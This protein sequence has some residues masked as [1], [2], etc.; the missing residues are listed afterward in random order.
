MTRASSF[1]DE[2]NRA[3]TIKDE[4][5]PQQH[6]RSVLTCKV[7]CTNRDKFLLSRRSVSMLTFQSDW[8]F[9]V[10]KKRK[11]PP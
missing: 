10:E 1:F 8:H 2:H 4:K 3:I 6:Q 9:L 7:I 11:N 5:L